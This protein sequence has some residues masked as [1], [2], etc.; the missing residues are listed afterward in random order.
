MG[1]IGSGGVPAPVAIRAGRHDALAPLRAGLADPSSGWRLA[2]KGGGEPE[3][4]ARASGFDRQSDYR[5]FWDIGADNSITKNDS[6]VLRDLKPHCTD[7]A[8]SQ[9]GDHILA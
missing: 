4:A 5:C 6:V 8:Y 2:G 9:D 7:I 3:L 1:A